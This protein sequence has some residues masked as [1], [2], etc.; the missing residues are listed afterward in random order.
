M[1]YSIIKAYDIMVDGHIVYRDCPFGNKT[2]MNKCSSK[3]CSCKHFV[4][5][6]WSNS[7]YG[8]VH[9]NYLTTQE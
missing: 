4:R 3:N 6:D 2:K 5:Y 8:H 7:H 1:S 9:C